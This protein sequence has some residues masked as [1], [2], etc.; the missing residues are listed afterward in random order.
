METYI[1][2]RKRCLQCKYCN[3]NSCPKMADADIGLISSCILNNPLIK[4]I[5]ENS[6]EE[7]L[8]I[9]EPI[10]L[11]SYFSYARRNDFPKAGASVVALTSGFNSSF[12]GKLLTVISQDDVQLFLKDENDN[13]YCVEN[14][15]WYKRIFVLEE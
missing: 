1:E 12:S 13:E 10:T 3:R 11:L 14:D 7:F 2:N 15:T 4:N 8:F 9:N 5:K 6:L